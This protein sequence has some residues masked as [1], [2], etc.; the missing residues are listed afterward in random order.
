MKEKS[1]VLIW[2]FRKS[3]KAPPLPYNKDLIIE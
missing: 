1:H 3:L 2:E